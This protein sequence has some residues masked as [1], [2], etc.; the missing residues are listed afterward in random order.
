MGDNLKKTLRSKIKKKRKKIN[1]NFKKH[2][3]LNTK[4]LNTRAINL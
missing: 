3:N 4:T 1:S 2:F